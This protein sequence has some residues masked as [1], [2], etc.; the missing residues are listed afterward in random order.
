MAKQVPTRWTT[1]LQSKVNLPDT[2]DFKAL[3]GSRDTPE[4]GRN[5]ERWTVIA[6]VCAIQ[7]MQDGNFF[8]AGEREREGE[9]GGGRDSVCV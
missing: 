5:A 2:I 6:G 4:S 9:R 3:R 1:H 7:A 8:S